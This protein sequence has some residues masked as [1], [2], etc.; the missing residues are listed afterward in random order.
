MDR[1]VSTGSQKR[2]FRSRFDAGQRAV[3]YRPIEL[4]GRGGMADVW[5]SEAIFDDGAAE[6]VAI[7]RIRDHLDAAVFAPMFDDEVRLGRFLVHP[8][9]VRMYDASR[10]DG[11]QAM[12]MELVDGDS[13]KGI[14]E[15]AGRGE[16]AVPLG[17]T[18]YVMRE[19]ANGLAYAHAVCD[20]W[21]D[22]IR[23]IH[24]DVSPHNVLLSRKGQ[25][26]LADFGLADARTHRVARDPHMVG[27]KFGYLAPEVVKQK[28]S[29]HRVDVF[30]MGIVLFETLVGR[31]LFQH[32][33]D[34]ETVMQVLRCEVPRLVDV[35]VRAPEQV[36]VLLDRLLEPD[37]DA[38]I[39]DAAH[40][41]REIQAV[42]D[43]VGEPVGSAQIAEL[44][45]AHLQ[46]ATEWAD[47][48]ERRVRDSE[49]RELDPHG[50]RTSIPDLDEREGASRPSLAG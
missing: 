4:I 17:L 37:P 12:V 24:R 27:G 46:R 35:D 45:E 38:R 40:A 16:L 19:L 26:K 33:D 39:P 32:E 44:V 47:E 50:Q 15:R 42:I 1:N 29:D 31:R 11:A 48:S 13:L 3:E 49:S 7:K 22:P 34:R 36:Q 20:E 9:L 21:G 14:T 43:A 23:V 10:I 6:P 41:A 2:T 30:A 8:N 28:P 18:L 25:V 5:R